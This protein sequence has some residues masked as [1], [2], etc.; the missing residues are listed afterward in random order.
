MN[1]DEQRKENCAHAFF[2]TEKHTIEVLCNIG[3]V[4]NCKDCKKF[5][6]LDWLKEDMET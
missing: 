1:D 2:T 3:D 5:Y 6:H 4:D